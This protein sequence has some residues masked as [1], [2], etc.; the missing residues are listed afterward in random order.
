MSTIPPSKP[1]PRWF[2]PSSIPPILLLTVVTSFAFNH[3]LISTQRK[4]DVRA[5]RIRTSLLQ[6]TIDYNSR[7]LFHLNPPSS[8]AGSW[9]SSSQPT[10][11]DVEPEWAAEER[12][13][14]VRRWRALGL[15]P[16][17]K[18]VLSRSPNSTPSSS[19]SS[20]S[21]SSGASVGKA[22]TPELIPRVNGPKEVTW[23][24][25]FLGSKEKRSSLTER[26]QK[27]TAGIKDSF[28]SLNPTQ[29]GN[30]RVKEEAET[31]EEEEKELEE[32]AKLWSSY[33]K[34]S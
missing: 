25:I 7:L 17:A 4:E 1:R 11:V 26:W 9:F 22:E 23:G 3:A 2:A 32:L 34:Q 19:S 14:L 33:S 20:S 31:S 29:Q 6:D 15:D 12:E 8:K 21:S 24:E 10:K 18:G 13:T 28:T 16:I 5:H 27:V 30:D